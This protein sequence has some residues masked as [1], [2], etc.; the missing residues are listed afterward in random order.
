V[1][2]HSEISDWAATRPLWQ[3]DALRRLVQTRVT[4]KDID[5]IADLARIEHGIA[6]S[7]TLTPLP[8]AAS[9]AVVSGNDR[10]IVVLTRLG[11]LAHVNA[12]ES[13]QS[14]TI[15]SA[16]LTIVH[17][18]NGAGKSGYVRVLKQVCRARGGADPVYSNVYV[19]DEEPASAVIEY[20]IND[21][22]LKID[23]TIGDTGP[24]DL[25]EV[26]IFD[27][28]SAAIYVADD[29]AVA[30]LP[31]GLDLFPRLSKI[32]DAVR[33]NLEQE[34]ARLTREL[35][36]W[37]DFPS[38]TIAF[39]CLQ[40]LHVDG[41]KETCELFAVLSDAERERLEELRARDRKYRSN[42]PAA[43]AIVL[44]QSVQR[45]TEAAL[46]WKAIASHLDF[47]AIADLRRAH[48]TFRT[49][50][51]AASI[52]AG[53]AFS[54]VPISGIGT[55]A[56]QLLWR[57]ARAFAEREATPSQA[58]PP[59]LG[60]LCVLCLQSV[61]DEV[62][63]RLARFETFVKGQIQR[64]V[65]AASEDLEK[66]RSLIGELRCG[67]IATPALLD[68][69]RTLDP[70]S[71]IALDESISE[72]WRRQQMALSLSGAEILQDTLSDPLPPLRALVGRLRSEAA[73]FEAASI[74]SERATVEDALR[75][76]EARERLAQVFDRIHIQI[77]RER[78]RRALGEAINA[79]NTAPITKC[80]RE[81][82]AK[83]ITAP[84]A[85]AF[86]KQRESLRLMHIPIR[87]E[88]TRGEKGTALHGLRLNQ[89]TSRPV[90]TASIL[91]EGEHRCIALAAFLAEVSLQNSESTL[92]FDDPVSSLDHGRRAYVARQVVL[93]SKRRP[94]LVFTHDLVFLWLLQEHADEEA[95]TYVARSIRRGGQTAGFIADEAPWDG[96]KVKQRIGALKSKLVHLE[97]QATAD[98]ERYESDIRL[99]YGRLRDTW[100]RAVEETLL[101]GAIRRFSPEI[102]TQ[103]LRKLHRLTPEQLGTLEAGMTKASNW[104]QGHDHAPELGAVP[105]LPEEARLDL[106]Q[107]E[108]WVRDIN[109]MHNG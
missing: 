33:S 84:L 11:E 20:R 102:K 1:T 19:D 35:D 108:D 32:C 60:E 57:T 77:E 75:E 107:L 44:R 67:E 10:A 52:A 81:L 89:S 46:R 85:E 87:V 69:L 13:R 42:D 34:H 63:Q 64:S 90:S 7:T 36:L 99:F 79:T 91:S 15:A 58:F 66:K 88:G 4:A 72:M 103:S 18:E 29:A 48:A 31:S 16:G 78:K 21:Q 49:A 54:D 8:L 39:R 104:V 28:R 76:L 94:V 9:D 17:G 50:S 96:Q 109:A 38:D 5:E 41:A 61:P 23:W 24:R 71:A 105:P 106:A 3:Q 82:L 12:L 26:S 59:H 73:T 27:A 6:T 47:D 65:D 68:E 62:A 83:T 43:R 51:E 2:L 70:A 80:S 14:L 95:A 45:V 92:V 101:Q 74:P 37:S 98:P 25:R 53:H 97:K 93:I 55:P 56:W 86:E 30:Y 100:E 40:R 22:P